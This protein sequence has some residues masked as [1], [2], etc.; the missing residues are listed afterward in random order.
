MLSRRNFITQSVAGAAAIPMILSAS[1]PAAKPK[2]GKK[3]FNSG[4]VVL[5]QGDSITD[6]GR[7][8]STQRPNDAGSFGN[9]YALMAASGLLSRFPEKQLV[10]YNRGISG[11][12]VFQLA[13]RWE[14]DCLAL[15][16][17]LLSILIGVN[18]YWH[19][20]SYGYDGTVAIY[21]N[22]YRALLKRTQNALPDTPIVICEPFAIEGGTAIGDKFQEEL[23][24][25]R[26]AARK[27]SEEFNTLFIPYHSIF[28]E[29]LKHAP[30][31]YWS[32]DGVHPSMAGAQL[33][34]NAWLKTVAGFNN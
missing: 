29:A 21:E 31:P 26:H 20:R 8:K 22:D 32:A 25:Y 30:A 11:N 17:K 12:K 23:E 7:N 34:A 13:E 33:M 27:L 14:A 24:P 19:K 4:D 2:G 6:A 3:L 10:I 9:G 16:P 15:A 28:I 1:L 18:D 5:F